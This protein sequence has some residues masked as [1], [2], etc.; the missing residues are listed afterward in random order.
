MT[1]VHNPDASINTDNPDRAVVFVD[2]LGFTALTEANTLDLRTLRALDRLHS[3]TLTDILAGAENPLTNAFRHFHFRLSSTIELAEMKHPLTAITFSD[4]AFV[5][6][7]HLF[8][9]STHSICGLCR[10]SVRG[11]KHYMGR[12]AERHGRRSGS[13]FRRSTPSPCFPHAGCWSRRR[14]QRRRLR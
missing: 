11:F 9:G 3:A 1:T 12:K 6:T 2:M 4:S 7:T 14:S 8:E 5:A 13:I 10:L